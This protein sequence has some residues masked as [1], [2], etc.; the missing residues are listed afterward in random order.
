MTEFELALMTEAVTKAQ[1]ER[2]VAWEMLREA[3][4]KRT[5]AEET[6]EEFRREREQNKSR[7]RPSQEHWVEVR[8]NENMK[9]WEA[10]HQGVVAYGDTPEMACDNFDHLWVFGDSE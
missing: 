1:L 3:I 10:S 4:A 6:L 5:Q 2:C 8:F 7:F 9:Q